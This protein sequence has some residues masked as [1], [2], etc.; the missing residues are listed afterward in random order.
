MGNPM[1]RPLFFQGPGPDTEALNAGSPADDVRLHAPRLQQAAARI[2]ALR[3]LDEAADHASA[4]VRAFLP[5]VLYLRPGE[6]ARFE[7]GAGNGRAL[8][9][10]AFGIALSVVNGGPLGGSVSP[11]PV[12]ADFP[13][14]APAGTDDLPALL[15]LFGLRQPAPEPVPAASSRP[16]AIRE[17]RPVDRAVLPDIWLRSVRAT[18]TFLTE[19]EIQAL[20]PFVREE[21]SGD[22]LELWVLADD[23]DSAV[24]FM[25]LADAKV[26]AL[27]LDPDQRRRGGG[28][29]LIDHAQRLRGTLSVD[30][31]EQN[32][33]AIRFYEAVGFETVSR[34]PVDDAGR[35]Y[36]VLRMR[37]RAA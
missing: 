20:L 2:A 11:H 37:Q 13:H 6:P 25:G 28:R 1:L 34:S 33:E 14:L 10:D 18:H 19:D 27:F 35:P 21:L 26:E 16:L 36:P 22:E 15:E 12:V 30:V 17:A 4:V 5:D 9:D 29:A 24:G 7:P 23:G 31:N 3:G 8:H 32:P